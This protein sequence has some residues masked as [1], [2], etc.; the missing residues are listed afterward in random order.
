MRE[1]EK[2]EKE[3]LCKVYSGLQISVLV[4]HAFRRKD[5]IVQ[6]HLIN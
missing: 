2:A 1:A 5:A 6:H 3:Q 4:K